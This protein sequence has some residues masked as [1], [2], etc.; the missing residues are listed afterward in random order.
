MSAPPTH[1]HVLCV[2]ILKRLQPAHTAHTAPD[3][4]LYALLRCSRFACVAC[5]TRH[6][7]LSSLGGNTKTVMCANAGPA[8]YNYDETVSTLR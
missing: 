4:V 6:T 2:R 7:P 3:L 8:E 5:T 1:V